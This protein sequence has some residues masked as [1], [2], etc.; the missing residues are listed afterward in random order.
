MNPTPT[1][2]AVAELATTVNNL[3]TRLTEFAA[4]TRGLSLNSVLRSE[5]LILDANGMATVSNETDFAHV[6]LVAYDSDITGVPHGPEASAPT[7][8]VGILIV[9]AGKGM[10]VP[11]VGREF[12]VYG[13]AA[14]RVLIQLFSRPQNLVLDLSAGALG[15][16]P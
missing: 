2:V 7:R 6:L 13:T 14:A 9:P 16:T 5:L 15:G 1:D 8:G 3:A 11:S 10:A 4:Q 12:T